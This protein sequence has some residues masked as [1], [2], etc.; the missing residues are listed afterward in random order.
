MKSK[1]NKLNVDKLVPDPVDLSKLNWY[2][3]KIMLL[4]DVYLSK[5][6]ILKIK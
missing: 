4:K 2:S 3:K 1:V 5:I 6:K